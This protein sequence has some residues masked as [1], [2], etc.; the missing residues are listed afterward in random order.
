MVAQINLGCCPISGQ[1]ERSEREMGGSV[2]D[3]FGAA[4]GGGWW[5]LWW[6]RVAE[7]DVVVAC[8]FNRE[9]RERRE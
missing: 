7:I 4:I 5:L 6:C 2:G 3:D 9:M 1:K 8:S